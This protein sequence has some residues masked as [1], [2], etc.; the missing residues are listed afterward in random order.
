MLIRDI[1]AL[2]DPARE[3]VVRLVLA[4]AA[5]PERSRRK[6]MPCVD[7]LTSASAGNLDDVLDETDRLIDRLERLAADASSAG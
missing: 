6:L 1:L 3:R 2:P 7:A 4:W 5:A